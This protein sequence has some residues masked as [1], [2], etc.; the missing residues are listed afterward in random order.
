MNKHFA[1]LAL[2][3]VATI[4]TASA[5]YVITKHFERKSNL[6]MAQILKDMGCCPNC[7]HKMDMCIANNGKTHKTGI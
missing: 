6:K 1:Q 2:G 5:T 4:A 3:A 7:M